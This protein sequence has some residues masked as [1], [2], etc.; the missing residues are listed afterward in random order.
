MRHSPRRPS[1]YQP[2][3]G[4]PRRKIR[5]HV[6]VV[7]SRQPGPRGHCGGLNPGLTPTSPDAPD[8]GRRR[9]MDRRNKTSRSQ[10]A[11]GSNRGAH[12]SQNHTLRCLAAVCGEGDVVE[13][14]EPHGMVD[15]AWCPEAARGR[16]R[17]VRDHRESIRDRYCRGR[18]PTSFQGYGSG[19]YP[20]PL[21]TSRTRSM[22][23]GGGCDTARRSR[24]SAP[25]CG[26]AASPG[27]S[28]GTGRDS[29]SD[30]QR[31][32]CSRKRV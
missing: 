26:Q 17:R 32:W 18:R 9:L 15:V 30:A 14:T 29:C 31:G 19:R 10:N 1:R 23:P 3:L 20:P 2:E 7:S 28:A 4:Q 13:D 21:A 24:R 12:P 8:Q 6:Q 5:Y 16:H 22:Y 11:A 27:R 25:E